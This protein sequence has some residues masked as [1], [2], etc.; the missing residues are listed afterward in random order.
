MSKE[1]TS[2]DR[3]LG[4]VPHGLRSP[5]QHHAVSGWHH[6]VCTPE[7]ISQRFVDISQCRQSYSQWCSPGSAHLT[8]RPPPPPPRSAALPLDQFQSPR[9]QTA[10]QS[11]ATA[12]TGYV[13]MSRLLASLSSPRVGQNYQLTCWKN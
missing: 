9:R 7:V 10:R 3:L 11:G 13:A 8:L 6:V 2:C 1:R 5:S 12:T 4:P